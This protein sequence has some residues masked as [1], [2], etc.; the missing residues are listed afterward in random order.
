MAKSPTSAKTLMLARA[1]VVGKVMESLLDQVDF[2]RIGEDHEPMLQSLCRGLMDEA[3]TPAVERQLGGPKGVDDAAAELADD[4][5]KM[6]GFLSLLQHSRVSDILVNGLSQI[7]VEQDGQLHATGIVFPSEG[8]L[9]RT[10][11][12]MTARIGRPVT[13]DRPM[14]DARLPDGS[15]LN[16]IIPPLALDGIVISIRRFHHQGLDLPGLARAGAYPEAFQPLLAAMVSCRLNILVSGGTGAG[17]TTMLNAMSQFVPER[18]RVVT[19]ED[20][21]ELRLRQ[22]HVVRL[23][24]RLA[25]AFGKGEVTTRMLVRN[26]LRMRPDRI[27]VGEVR[28]PEA[29]DMLQ[30]MNTGHEGSMSTIHANTPRDALERL[31]TMI[32]MSDVS[33]TERG[34][35]GQIARSIDA[36]LHVR[37]LPDGRRVVDRLSEVGQLQ[38]EMIA[39]QDVLRFEDGGGKGGHRF[40]ATG[41]RPSFMDRLEHRGTKIDARLWRLQQALPPRA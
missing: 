21:A 34:I 14:V 40:V 2:S 37:R 4:L 26:A 31:G 3:V 16:V 28:G 6:R 10:A 23:E 25:D 29:L 18:E 8:A 13:Q 39:M 17:K 33:F 22:T 27:L 20:S 11:L 5:I 30:A 38:G 32:G 19:I 36:I 1:Q 12:W 9:E 7:Y 15:R 35:R 41:V 24:T